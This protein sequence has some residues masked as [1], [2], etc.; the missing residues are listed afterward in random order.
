MNA[1]QVLPLIDQAKPSLELSTSQY[2]LQTAP[3]SGILPL[4]L[5]Y[6]TGFDPES[7]CSASCEWWCKQYFHPW[8]AKATEM[9]ASV[10]CGGCG[11]CSSTDTNP[12]GA[13]PTNTPKKPESAGLQ[14]NSVQWW[15][16]Q[17]AS[18]TPHVT[19]EPSLQ[20]NKV[21]YMLPANQ[22][23]S[24]EP[25]IALQNFL[26]RTS[27]PSSDKSNS[28]HWLVGGDSWKAIPDAPEDMATCERYLYRYQ[29]QTCSNAKFAIFSP[30]SSTKFSKTKSVELKGTLVL[31][32]ETP[33][34]DC[35]DAS[36]LHFTS[37]SCKVNEGKLDATQMFGGKPVYGQRASRF[38][39]YVYNSIPGHT[40]AQKQS[41]SVQTAYYDCA[42]FRAP[43][44][45]D[46]SVASALCLGYMLLKIP[47]LMYAQCLTQLGL[48]NGFCEEKGILRPLLT[49]ED[50][51]L[52]ECAALVAN[53]QCNDEF[54]AKLCCNSCRQMNSGSSFDV[55][56][57]PN[58]SSTHGAPV[59]TNLFLNSLLKAIGADS[60]A[61]DHEFVQ[62]PET[63][64]DL[65]VPD[66]LRVSSW[67]FPRPISFTNLS[68]AS[69]AFLLGIIISIALAFVPPTFALFIVREKEFMQR[70]QQAVSGLSP[71]IYWL[72]NFTYDFLA[73][74][75]VLT[76]TFIC[77]AIAQVHGGRGCGRLWGGLAE[78]HTCAVP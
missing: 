64:T 39:A 69:Y 37:Y 21:E 40:E 45:A 20:S 57:L 60:S 42:R 52:G 67:P 61:T 36:K 15:V 19:V 66:E 62:H 48:L 18:V 25:Y 13:P 47:P 35:F 11:P 28:E 22:T 68:N 76:I 7:T 31:G 32:C 55:T 14:P 41:Q 53:G 54:R 3:N 10:P 27:G 56:V 75:A 29:D 6:T 1:A 70:H 9:C 2:N 26:L 65:P 74:I 12:C 38:G 16:E 17:L 34:A 58:A 49:C 78:S 43:Q 23:T 24:D 73:L 59:F 51:F 71:T 46:N 5:P 8:C 30:P 44:G 33:A 77:F 63:S 50:A 4:P 72:S